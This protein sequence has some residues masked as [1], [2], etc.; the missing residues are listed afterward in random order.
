[1]ASNQTEAIETDVYQDGR[2]MAVISRS[3]HSRKA[4]LPETDGG[5]A[6]VV[7]ERGRPKPECWVE[8]H[9]EADYMLVSVRSA[10]NH[11][12]CKRCFESDELSEQNAKNGASS[13]IGRRLTH[14]DDWGDE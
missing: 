11:G 14:G 10:T 1:M 6:I 12:K 7:D 5:G 3:Q 9:V 13:T 2:E 8:P 4:H